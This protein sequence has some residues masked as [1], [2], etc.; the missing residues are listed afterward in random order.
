MLS[1]IALLLAAILWVVMNVLLWRAEYGHSVSTGSVVPPALIWKKMLTAA[2]PSSLSIFHH[3]KKVGFCHWTTSVG[4]QLSAPRE[5]TPA[6]PEGM[7]QRITG[8]RVQL[9]GNLMASNS[10]GRIRFESS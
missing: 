10:P 9:E 8:Y 3:A 7:V 6:T 1:R 2:D 4:E 5:D